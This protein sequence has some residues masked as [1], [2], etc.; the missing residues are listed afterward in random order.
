MGQLPLRLRP[1]A[2]RPSSHVLVRHGLAARRQGNE[3]NPHVGSNT[4]YDPEAAFPIM[5]LQTSELV[6]PHRARGVTD[7]RA[8]AC[9]GFRKHVSEK[10]LSQKIGKS[11]ST[12][13]HWIYVHNKRSQIIVPPHIAQRWKE[14][15]RDHLAMRRVTFTWKALTFRSP[16]AVRC[17]AR[18]AHEKLVYTGKWRSVSVAS[19][20]PS[21]LH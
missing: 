6:R 20:L 8:S 10:G 5:Q 21:L 15:M 2:R 7:D 4:K 18:L 16:H 11:I 14:G 19:R 13:R 3:T 17:R 1:R 12:R 9:I